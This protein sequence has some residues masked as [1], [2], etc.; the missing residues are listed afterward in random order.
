MLRLKPPII[1]ALSF[2]LVILVGGILLSLPLASAHGLPTNFLDACFTANSATCVTGLVTL[3]TG[4][5]FSLFGLVVIMGLMQLGGLGYMTFSVFMVLV[6]R[7]KLFI[8]QKL[9]IREALNIYSTKDVIMVM[10][11]IFTIVFTIEGIGALILF[12]RWWPELGVKKGLLYAVFHAVSAFNNAGFALPAKFANLTPYAT[13]LV[14]NLTITSLIIIGGIGFMVIA[15]IL[16]HK[17]LSL[18]SKIVLLVTTLLIAIGTIVFFTL[19]HNNPNTL[20]HF[21]LHE[22]V[23]VSY[24]QAVTPRT[25]GFN[26]IDISLLFNPTLLITMFLMFVGASPGGTGGGIKTT[27]FALIIATIWA[28]LRGDKNTILFNRR[29]PAETTRRA[30]AITFL[31]L[32]AVAIAIFILNNLE[33][34]GLME[35]GFEVFS[36]FGTVGLSM[37]ITPYLSSL[38]KMII[39]L[40]MFIGRVGPLTLMMALAI[41]QREARAIPPKE[42]I[43][44]G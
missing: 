23:L 25:A 39:M 5:H 33:T 36:A 19:E 10:K 28:T 15:D 17:R 42:G 35:I 29:I 16:E 3:D 31:S 14:I 2:F 18:H 4:V 24:F 41:E 30:F 38:G 20:G 21:T 37:G 13:D 32:T 40:V 12:L 27:T 22:K 44:I 11:R 43:S 1:I 26:T 8:S 34:F 9:A 7:Q 6:F